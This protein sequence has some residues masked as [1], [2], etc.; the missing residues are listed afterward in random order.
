MSIWLWESQLE[1]SS[2]RR[3][4]YGEGISYRTCNYEMFVWKKEEKEKEVP[5]Y[6]VE[7][8]MRAMVVMN[9]NTDELD[10]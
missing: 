5:L 3:Q 8:D 7:L 1:M 6:L 10:Q 4:L 2:V 9:L